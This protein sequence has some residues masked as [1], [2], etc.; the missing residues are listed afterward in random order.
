MIF[1]YFIET[2]VLLN[3]WVTSWDTKVSNIWKKKFSDKSLKKLE[4]N[5]FK[6]DNFI[7]AHVLGNWSQTFGD[8]LDGCGAVGRLYPLQ[9]VSQSWTLKVQ[10]DS[11]CRLFYF[12]ITSMSTVTMPH[13]SGPME[14]TTLP[15]FPSTVSWSPLYH[16]SI[17]SSLPCF[18]VFPPGVLVSVTWK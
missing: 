14:E 5:G 18:M 6:Q 10:S 15:A 3:H 16:E 2:T 17:W 8:G 9:E 12:L 4:C 11:W 7:Y 1:Y 13:I